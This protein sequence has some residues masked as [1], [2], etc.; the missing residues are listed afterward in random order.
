MAGFLH[1]ARA[2]KKG[3]ELEEARKIVETGVESS[4]VTAA[5]TCIS[6]LMAFGEPYRTDL[7]KR[8]AGMGYTFRILMAATVPTEGALPALMHGVVSADPLLA[9][10]SATLLAISDGPLP[11]QGPVD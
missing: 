10:V 6:G 4:D 1:L 11:I 8:C 9:A 3:E 2:G 7:P 5:W